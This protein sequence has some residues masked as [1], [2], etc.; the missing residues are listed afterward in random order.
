MNI[1]SHVFVSQNGACQVELNYDDKGRADVHHRYFRSSDGSEWD[2]SK[3]PRRCTV[4]HVQD[5]LKKL[6]EDTR[7]LDVSVFD[8]DEL[9]E[10][11]D[12]QRTEHERLW[13]S[14]EP[15]GSAWRAMGPGI[16]PKSFEDFY[17]CTPEE[18]Y[19]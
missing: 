18:Y 16:K 15:T 19:K 7:Y 9:S 1:T 5:Y 8:E 11:R 4:E 10:W 2:I 6:E 13:C 12:I 14:N 3:Y 17:G